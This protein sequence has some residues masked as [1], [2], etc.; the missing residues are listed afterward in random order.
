MKGE[1]VIEIS[2]PISKST[3]KAASYHRIDRTAVDI[4]LVSSSTCISINKQGLILDSKIA[5]GAVA[6]V[7]LLAKK[8]SE[9]LLGK[10]LN[11]IDENIIN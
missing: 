4:S 2:I 9:K 10:S 3:I 8:A 7:V 11:D 1:I 5:L 6:P